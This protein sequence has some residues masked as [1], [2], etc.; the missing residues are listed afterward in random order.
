[1]TGLLVTGMTAMDLLMQVPDLPRAGVKY[2]ATDAALRLGGCA[3]NAAVAAARLGGQVRLV[4]RMG[5]D[6]L[7]GAARAALGAEGIDLSGLHVTPGALMPVS[8][9]PIDSAGQRQVVNFRGAGLSETPDPA[10]LSLDGINAV[11][12]DTRWP[13]AGLAALAA[14]RSSGLPAVLDGE[15]PVPRAMAEAAT[16][17]AFA[18]AGLAEFTGID[19][20][21]RALEAA[22]ATLDATLIVTDG[23]AGL[24]WTDGRAV[25]HM[26]A[27]D[28]DVRDT[29]GAGDVWH[30]AFALALGEGQPL[31]AALRFASA[32]A[33]LKCMGTGGGS[34]APDRA[35]TLQ[36]LKDMT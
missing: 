18:R 8:S 29:L 5:D 22:A 14:A 4:S 1:M 32:A 27:F 36:F 26:P 35:R 23:E 21:D 30:G 9:V 16:H 11:L 17:V 7:S 24:W 34:A 20:P 13:E 31:D 3:A 33:A 25:R 2:R 28:V 10:S 6:L 15:A 19:S 12:A